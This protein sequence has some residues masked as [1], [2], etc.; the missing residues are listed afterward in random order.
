MSLLTLI[1]QTCRAPG[2]NM[3]VP[4]AVGTSSN[5][6]VLQLLEIANEEG[7]ELARRG[8]W[9][10]LLKT[11]TFTT[12]ATSLQTTLA[13][14]AP[15]FDYMINQTFWNTTLRRPMYG[16]LSVQE[17]RQQVAFVALGPWANYIILEGKIYFVPTPAA[18]NTC[19]FSFVTKAWCTSSSGTAQTALLADSDV[20][21]LDEQLMKLGIIWRWR[22]GKGLDYAE[23][24]AKYER[25]AADMLG[26]DGSKPVLNMGGGACDLW[27]WVFVP[28]G[29]WPT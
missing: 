4:N 12:V 8:Q 27:P 3:P 21:L 26:R 6:T 25:M 9:Q 16:P 17:Y 10:A 19:T 14:V 7:V 18:G 24:Y 13:A 28:A 29:S 22:Q 11:A 2:V 23:D 15:N 1:R 20:S 5:D